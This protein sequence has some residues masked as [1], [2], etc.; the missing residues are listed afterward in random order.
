LSQYTWTI[1]ATLIVILAGFIGY[2]LLQRSVNNFAAKEY[3]SGSLDWRIWQ[4]KTGTQA[5]SGKG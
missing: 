5:H 2:C 4:E 3:I 1:T